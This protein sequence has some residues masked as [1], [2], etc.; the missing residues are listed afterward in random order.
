MGITELSLDGEFEP[1]FPF[2]TMQLQNDMKSFI[3]A[4]KAGGFGGPNTLR[5]AAIRLLGSEFIETE[6][7]V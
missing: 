7:R 2:G 5:D 3:V 4:M 1:G 6:G